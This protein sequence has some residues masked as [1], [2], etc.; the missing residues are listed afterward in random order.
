MTYEC[1]GARAHVCEL[2]W[3]FGFVCVRLSPCACAHVFFILF[4]YLFFA[5]SLLFFLRCLFLIF[6]LRLVGLMFCCFFVCL[7]VCFV[8]SGC[9]FF[10]YIVETLAAMCIHSFVCRYSSTS[11]VVS[12]TFSVSV[13]AFL[14]LC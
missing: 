1:V 13:F 11:Y 6:V 4:I 8:F 10:M 7:Y 14:C 5:V 3:V 2:L 9:F 12:H